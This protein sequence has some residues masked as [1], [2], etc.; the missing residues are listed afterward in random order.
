MRFQLLLFAI[1]GN[2]SSP[3]FYRI[4]ENKREKDFIKVVLWQ[5]IEKIDE[6]SSSWLSITQTTVCGRHKTTMDQVLLAD[7]L[8]PF[9]ESGY[10]QA[11]AEF[12]T[13]DLIR[14]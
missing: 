7:E 14:L 2:Y 10:R 1:L 5:R 3:P 6:L 11:V 12:K 13:N 8:I 4:E 9:S